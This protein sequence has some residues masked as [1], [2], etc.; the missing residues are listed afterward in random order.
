VILV[1]SSAWIEVLRDTESRADR[2]F[3][4]LLHEE[5]PL[6]TTEAVIGEVLAGARD[7]L[8]HVRLRRRLHGLRFLTIGGLAGFERAA[9]LSQHCRSRGF[10]PSLADCLVAV[11]ALATGAAVLHADSHFDA[12]AAVTALECYPLD[13]A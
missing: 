1:D 2:T 5:V 13:A 10:S 4:R 7:E 6:A 12:I 8:E 11:P 3:R 9:R